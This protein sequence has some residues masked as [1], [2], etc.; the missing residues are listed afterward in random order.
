MP[1]SNDTPGGSESLDSYEYDDSK[2]K[3]K[4]KKKRRGS[5][6]SVSEYNTLISLVRK[7]GE[8]WDTISKQLGNKSAKQCMQKFK[9]SQRSAKKG[10]WSND[11]NDILLDWV[12]QNGPTKWTE[13]SKLLKGRC[14]KQCWE[15]W[16]NILNPVV[17]KGNWSDNEQDLI[18][19]A[20][21]Q[22]HTS[23]SAMSKILKGWTENSIK[24][25]FYSSIRW[26]K[27]SI[28]MTLIS[29]VFITRTKS[30]PDWAYIQDQYESELL[31]FNRLS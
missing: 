26:I 11:E 27:S 25:Y 17:K 6:W 14:G 10:N 21:A 7:F 12:K 24:N 22:H 9:N 19:D 29:E 31:R 3:K 5:G 4:L 30:K 28:I 20:L 13:C 2:Y 23:W 16:V 8:E 15:R 1:D 18:F